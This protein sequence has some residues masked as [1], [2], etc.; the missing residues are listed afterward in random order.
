MGAPKEAAVRL[1]DSS[2]RVWRGVVVFPQRRRTEATDG[3]DEYVAAIDW[4]RWI[5]DSE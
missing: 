4:R 2:V 3:I 5:R 1:W